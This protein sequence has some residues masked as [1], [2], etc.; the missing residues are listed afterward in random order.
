MTTPRHDEAMGYRGKLAE[1]QRARE[2]R[3]QAWT[4]PDIAKELG[5]SKSSVSLWV[6]DVEFTPNPRRHNYWTKDNPHPQQVAK[7]QEIE[8]FR[9][10]GIERIGTLSEREFLVL[11]LALYAGEGTKKGSTVGFANSDPKLIMAFVTWLRRFFDIDEAKLR[12]KLYLHAGLDLEAANGFWS[13]LTGIPTCQFN[14][15][16]R[17]VADQSI[18]SSKHVMG[19]PSVVYHSTTVLRRVMGMVEA[20]TSTTAFPG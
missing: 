6:R 13:R 15:A 12:V 3:A 16:Y 9:V 1:Q 18:R 19:C 17:P 8:R 10:E 14:R 5:V 2:L 7:E 20:L 4:L 11:G